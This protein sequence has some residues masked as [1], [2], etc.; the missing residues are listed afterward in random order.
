MPIVGTIAVTS[1]VLIL[2]LWKAGYLKKTASK[3]YQQLP[4][5]GEGIALNAEEAREILKFANNPRVSE[6]LYEGKYYLALESDGITTYRYNV[7]ENLISAIRKL[8]T[9][10][11]FVPQKQ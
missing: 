6:H 1:G 10:C 11:P 4:N 5:L 8:R 2:C 9:P 3:S 7:S